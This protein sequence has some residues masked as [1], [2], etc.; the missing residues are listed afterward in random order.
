[1]LRARFVL[2]VLVAVALAG[3][4]VPERGRAGNVAVGDLAPPF[5][6][7]T[8]DGASGTADCH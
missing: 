8:L 4:N 6:I 5:A 1:M 3:A 7:D 2:F